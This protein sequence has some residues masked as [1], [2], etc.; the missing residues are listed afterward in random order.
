ME[1]EKWK[2]TRVEILAAMPYE[3]SNEKSIEYMAVQ[4]QNSKICIWSCH[5]NCS[6]AH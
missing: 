5:R 4:F 2:E 6:T 1:E 3:G